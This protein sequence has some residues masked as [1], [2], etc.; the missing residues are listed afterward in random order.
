[1]PLQFIDRFAGIG[2]FHS[3]ISRVLPDAQCV[4]ASDIDAKARSTYST[5]YGVEPVGDIRAIPLDST[6]P[7]FSLLCAGFPCQAF[8]AAGKKNAFDDPRGTLFFD[9]LKII[10]HASPTTMVFENVAN[11]VTINKGSVFKT[12]LGEL[13]SR[14]YRVA[15]CILSPHQ[16]GIPQ[17]RQ[18]IYIVASRDHDFDF[19]PLAA[20]QS[21]PTLE[22]I[23]DTD[24]PASSYLDPSKYV[25]LP[26]VQVKRQARTGMKFCGYIRGELRKTGVR[27]NTEHLSR[28][29]KQTARIHS[30]EGTHPTLSASETSGRYH[31]YDGK[32]VRKL[33]V[34]ECY[35]LMDYP[36]T[37]AK[38]PTKGVAYHQ[39]GNSVCVKVIEEIIREMVRQRVL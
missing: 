9:I 14:G 39:I 26:E 16:F 27:E 38:H 22:S 2:G 29:H 7:A 12:I 1:M 32:G 13:T 34:T 5:N 3:A 35:R 20:R 10:D 24:I 19:S 18:R 8:S 30:V 11:L 28:V 23:L 31:I 6:L 15:H 37:F 4:L 33:T 17:S 25:L 36:D 21:T